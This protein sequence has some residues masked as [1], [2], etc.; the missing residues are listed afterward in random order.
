[1]RARVAVRVDAGGKVVAVTVGA[2][3]R[4]AGAR[5]KGER[6][7]PAEI[8]KTE[9]KK[10]KVYEKAYNEAIKHIPVQKPADPWGKMR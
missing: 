9:E 8:K 7:K 4:P 10:P 3:P 2:P 6:R 5:P 1:M